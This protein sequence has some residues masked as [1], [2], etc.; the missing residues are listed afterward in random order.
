MIGIFGEQW[1]EDK[2]VLAKSEP[3]PGSWDRVRVEV[4]RHDV[5]PLGDESED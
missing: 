2:P 3:W 5:L 4:V 1:A